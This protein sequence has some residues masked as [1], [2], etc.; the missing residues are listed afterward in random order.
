MEQALESG[1]A[2][3][4]GMARPFVR[5]PA[6]VRRIREGRTDAA[7]C[8]SCNRCLAAIANEMELRCYVRGLRRGRGG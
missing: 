5:E 7:S 6:L 8:V 1:V 3:L 4:V 2:D